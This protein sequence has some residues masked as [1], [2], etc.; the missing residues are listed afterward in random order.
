MIR[1]CICALAA[2]FLLIYT[3]PQQAYAAFS[4]DADPQALEQYQTA[5]QGYQ[6]LLVAY[7]NARDNWKD[8][9]TKHKDLSDPTQAQIAA[10]EAKSYTIKTLSAYK[11]YLTLI[12]TRVEATAG[13]DEQVRATIYSELE[14]A[15]A[16]LETRITSLSSGNWTLEA[17]RSLA[18]EFYTFR[19][20][21][22]A[23][24]WYMADSLLLSRIDSYLQSFGEI[25]P[26]LDQALLDQSL[27]LT[28]TQHASLQSS[29]DA[30]R[31]ALTQIRDDYGSVQALI[32][33]D[34]DVI[35]LQ[36]ALEQ[37]T[38]LNDRIGTLKTMTS[39]LT[40][41]KSDP[42]NTTTDQPIEP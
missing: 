13:I 4:T 20:T 40:T 1:T 39:R 3:A 22:K 38:R 24:V 25:L 30:V 27:Y 23:K 12:R 6:S 9:R 5:Q 29:I 32:T 18:D 33:P 37:I 16:W 8:Y 19:E 14:V 7:K 35:A 34:Y 26:A 42:I 41:P 2:A 36:S 17:L 31:S 15:A 10:E 21:M 11:A 28:I